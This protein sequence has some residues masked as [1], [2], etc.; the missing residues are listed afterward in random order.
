MYW[1]EILAIVL[2]AVALFLTLIALINYWVRSIPPKKLIVV[3]EP[4]SAGSAFP[5]T[6]TNPPAMP[7]TLSV[8][9][10]NPPVIP[11]PLSVNLTEMRENGVNSNNNN[12]TNGIPPHN[13]TTN[14]IPPH[15]FTNVSTAGF[16]DPMFAEGNLD[17][18]PPPPPPSSSL[19]LSCPLPA[20]ADCPPC[21]SNNNTTIKIN[22]PKVYFMKG[23]S[24]IENTSIGRA[25]IGNTSIRRASIRDTSIEPP[26]EESPIFPVDDIGI[27][28]VEPI[29]TDPSLEGVGRRCNPHALGAPC[30]NNLKCSSLRYRCEQ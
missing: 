16:I 9:L 13:F 26:N 6:L 24:S 8:N 22:K 5:V 14:S 10:I 20:A 29:L 25:S 28:S 1:V 12:F 11:N 7:S 15:N 2:F 3:I 17:L 18:P 4:N 19:P 21:E 30:P 27:S 23:R